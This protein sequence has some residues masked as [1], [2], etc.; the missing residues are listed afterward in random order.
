VIFFFFCPSPAGRH[1]EGRTRGKRRAPALF[2][3]VELWSLLA[4]HRDQAVTAAHIESTRCTLARS[5]YMQSIECHLSLRLS[6]TRLQTALTKASSFRIGIG[7]SVVH[8][9]E[10]KIQM[11]A[12]FRSDPL[13]GQPGRFFLTILTYTLRSCGH[14]LNLWFYAPV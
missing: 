11:C 10:K 13:Q 14:T 9:R 3:S 2:M 8:T 4:G 7:P 5:P 6:C 1:G 12:R